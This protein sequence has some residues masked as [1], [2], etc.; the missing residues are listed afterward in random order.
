MYEKTEKDWAAPGFGSGLFVVVAVYAYSV[1][2]AQWW[3][4]IL[5]LAGGVLFASAV[6]N[7]YQYIRQTQ[8]MD[9]MERQR[10]MSITADSQVFDSARYL[11]A[12]SPE[13]AGELAKRFGRPDLVL[14][15]HRQGKRAQIKLAGSDVTIEFALDALNK[16]DER[17][18]VAQRNY[19]DSTY[20]YDGNKEISDRMQWKQLNWILARD[21]ICTRYVEGQITNTPPM[22]LPPWTAASVRE[23]WLFPVYLADLLKPWIIT[24]DE[25]KAE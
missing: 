24:E 9:L 11:A 3:I 6:A 10:A 14:L 12:Q 22:W 5:L 7:L 19:A 23:N 20:H 1:F 16:S 13:L 8:A 21:G 25:N 2:G 4:A 17:Y 18:F 15:P